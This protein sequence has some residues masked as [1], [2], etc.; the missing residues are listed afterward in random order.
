MV[1]HWNYPYERLAYWDKFGRPD[2]LPQMTSG[3]T[4]IWWVDPEK[5]KALD[6]ARAE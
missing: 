4:Q 1:P 5:K 6:A 2:K 3:L